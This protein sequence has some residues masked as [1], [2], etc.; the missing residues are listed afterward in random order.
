MKAMKLT[1]F[2]SFLSALILLSA[3]GD[4]DTP[5][6]P[7][8]T[9]DAAPDA[10]PDATAGTCLH[11]LDQPLSW[12]WVGGFVAWNQVS[13]IGACEMYALARTPSGSD[14]PSM[15]C[16]AEISCTE[17]DA[18]TMRDISAAVGHA[19]VTRAF[20]SGIPIFGRDMRFVDA[21]IYSIT[22]GTQTVL[23]GSPC[24]GADDCTEPPEGLRMLVVFLQGLETEMIRTDACSAFSS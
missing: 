19:H 8:A 4:D 5:M 6:M 12:G 17:G 13:S 9:P 2:L 1:S 7:D 21:P 23:V 18:T 16:E 20:G 15:T 10:T 24:M 3:C 14:R 11:C 22:Y